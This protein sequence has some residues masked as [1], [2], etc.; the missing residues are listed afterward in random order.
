MLIVKRT[1]ITI[2]SVS[3]YVSLPLLKIME[4]LRY[5]I[6]I[7]YNGKNYH[8]WQVQPD[9]TSIQMVLEHAL[10]TVL[11]KEIKVTG[12]GR[13]DT[14]VHA[15]QLYAHF[16]HDEIED[17]AEIVFRL[18][19]FLPKDIS[20]KEFIPVRND[21]HARFD[22]TQR[23]Y[24]YVISLQKDPF[25]QDYAYLIHHEP[26]IEKMNEAANILLEYKDFQCFSRNKTAVKT[27]HCDIK[28][29]QW[30]RKDHRLIFTISA[31]RFLRNM[32]RAI[33][34]T[35]LEIGFE[36]ISMADFHDIIQSKDRSKAGTSAPAHGL[37]LT[38]VLYPDN[39]K[40]KK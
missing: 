35:L 1:Q 23:E 9:A 28:Q 2:S 39:I 18:N 40:I 36:K 37:Y 29:V 16:D 26:N 6:E 30:E 22:A 12:A 3:L 20:V 5:F 13:T 34:G 19:S 38:K 32:V 25:Q 27:Y 11:R 31:D 33:V 17:T 15:K 8:G 14:G 7:A 24:E 21:A 10:S 4:S